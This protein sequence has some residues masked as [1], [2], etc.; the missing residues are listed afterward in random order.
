[1]LVLVYELAC[2][3]N[4]RLFLEPL[5]E[6]GGGWGE[7]YFAN[8]IAWRNRRKLESQEHYDSSYA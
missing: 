4:V 6:V 1:M 8:S 2:S 3:R 5:E 7:V